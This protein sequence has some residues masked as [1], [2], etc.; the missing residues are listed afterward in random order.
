MKLQRYPWDKWFKAR[1]VSI[2]KGKDYKCQTHGMMQQI[3]NEAS[4]RCIGV[5]ISI[6]G[7]R[8]EFGKKVR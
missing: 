1:K 3:R 6:D 2:V 5:S 7:N 8:I 4:K